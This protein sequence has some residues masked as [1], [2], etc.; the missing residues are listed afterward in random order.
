M[1]PLAGGQVDG[2]HARGIDLS[3]RSKNRQDGQGHFGLARKHR[4]VSLSPRMADI[5]RLGLAVDGLRVFDRDEQWAEVFRDTDYGDAF[6][7]V[8]FAADGRLATTSSDGMI[9]LYDSDFRLVTPRRM[10]QAGMNPSG[11]PSAPTARSSR[12]ATYDVAAVDL[13]DGLS[14][15]QLAGPN[16]DG[17]AIGGLTQSCLV[18][19]WRRP[20]CGR[21]YHEDGIP[22]W[23]GLTRAEASGAPCRPGT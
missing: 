13:F 16:L 18:G 21:A 6:M 3:V 11:S 4:I 23:P 8:A 7:V 5:W 10:A 12:S 1:W 2:R 17:L 15:A 22:F 9:R 19:G 20:L 14:L